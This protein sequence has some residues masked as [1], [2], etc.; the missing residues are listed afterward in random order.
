MLDWKCWGKKLL[1]KRL[2][3]SS[4]KEVLEN[5][6]AVQRV[7]C[8]ATATKIAI[9][10]RRFLA[11]FLYHMAVTLELPANIK[12]VAQYEDITSWLQDDLETII[13]NHLLKYEDSYFKTYLK[14][15]DAEILLY[16][17]YTKNKQEKY[18]GK[19][20]FVLDHEEFYRENNVPFKEP[21]DV[22]NH[23]FKHLKEYIS[24]K[25]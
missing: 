15:P 9:E 16:V 4:S 6:T 8:I 20:K 22:V 24:S 12:L 7:F 11:I 1:S 25:K 2:K 14:N 3:E 21:F 17:S 13:K 19:F 18:E 10:W 23:A 5:R